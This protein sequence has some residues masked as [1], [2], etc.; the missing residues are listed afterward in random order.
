[1][2][3]LG[4]NHWRVYLQAVAVELLVRMH[5]DP[6]FNDTYQAWWDSQPSSEDIIAPSLLTQEHIAM[7]Q[8]TW[9]VSVPWGGG[10]GVQRVG[11]VDG[12]AAAAKGG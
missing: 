5:T 1:M 12:A 11:A 4:A 6:A 3:R 7:L 8:S 10:L 9:L 2:G